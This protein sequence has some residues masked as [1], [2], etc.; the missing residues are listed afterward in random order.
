V[1]PFDPADLQYEPLSEICPREAFS[2]GA[3]IVDRWF[4]E[5]AFTEHDRHFCRVTTIH[6]PSD[7]CPVAFYAVSVVAER[8]TDKK[9]LIPNFRPDDKSYFPSLRLEW[10]AVRAD[11]QGMGLGTIVMGRVLSVFKDMV[12]STGIPALTLRPLNDRAESFY[13]GLE[14]IPFGARGLGPRM[15]LPAQKVIEARTALDRE[16]ES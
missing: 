3:E 1:L 8:L 13:R 7:P 4:R 5:K 12:N 6:A 14:F 9:S 16:A 2:C 15:L 10:T 11:L